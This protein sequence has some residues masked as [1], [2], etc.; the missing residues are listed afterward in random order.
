MNALPPEPPPPPPPW[1]PPVPPEPELTSTPRRM[2]E[3]SPTIPPVPAPLPVPNAVPIAPDALVSV[4]EPGRPARGLPACGPRGPG[5]WFRGPASAT[6]STVPA[7]S[8][9]GSAGGS[10]VS[11]ANST[12]TASSGIKSRAGGTGSLR[13]TIARKAAASPIEI[14][15]DP[16]SARPSS[17]AH[18]KRRLRVKVESGRRGAGA[19][20]AVAGRSGV[21]MSARLPLRS[22]AFGLHDLKR[23]VLEAGLPRRV[24][25]P[26]EQIV[27][28]PLVPLYREYGVD[29]L[30]LWNVVRLS[31]RVRG[32]SQRLVER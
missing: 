23:D 27:P 11:G 6:R 10:I 22:V 16:T 17:P 1:P 9:T 2:P 19:P 14:A 31:D 24:Q 3:T 30:V 15:Y 12:T 8:T 20:P 26:G 25:Y 7:C 32:D 5:G 21:A 13:C 4:R 18:S 29:R 28:H